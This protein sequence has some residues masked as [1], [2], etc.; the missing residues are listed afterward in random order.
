MTRNIVAKFQVSET[1]Q[2]QFTDQDVNFDFGLENI[3][4]R[5]KFFETLC[6][7]RTLYK[8]SFVKILLKSGH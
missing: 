6:D 4:R 1:L 2:W 8:A 5:S 7:L 3:I